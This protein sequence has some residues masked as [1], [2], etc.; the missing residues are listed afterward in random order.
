MRGLRE[1]TYLA[2]EPLGP[3]ALGGE[4]DALA[5]APGGL[6]SFTGVEP[7]LLLEVSM[8][9]IVAD[10]WFEDPAIP[11]GGNWKGR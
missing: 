7:T 4:A 8:P 10:N 6:H 2:D 9:G 11:I 5:V 3:V 1:A